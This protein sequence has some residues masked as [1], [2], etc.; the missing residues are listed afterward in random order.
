MTDELQEHLNKG[1]YGTPKLKPDEQRKYLGTFRER[2]DLTVTFA[3]L[4]SEKY[5]PAIQKE[6]E[7]HPKYRMT[8]NGSV[9][10]DQ[11]SRLIQIASSANAAFTCSS[12]L[13]LPPRSF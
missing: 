6:L 1:M 9:D 10:Q 7:A 4:N 3:Q 13:T 8:I 2:V 5:Y 11:L 12:D